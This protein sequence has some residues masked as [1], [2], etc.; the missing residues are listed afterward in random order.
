MIFKAQNCLVRNNYCK[1]N[2]LHKDINHYK[3]C[4]LE[5]VSFE[6][7]D[8]ITTFLL[9]EYRIHNVFLC[10]LAFI[11]RHQVMFGIV[12]ID[13]DYA[14]SESCKSAVCIQ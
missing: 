3:L 8:Q 5:I 14:S 7:S 9:I 11:G 2:R 10:F 1:I 12:L 6:T 13:V 4:Q